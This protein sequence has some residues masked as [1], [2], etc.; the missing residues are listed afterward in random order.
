MAIREY[1]ECDTAGIP[2]TRLLAEIKTNPAL[3][4]GSPMAVSVEISM[5]GECHIT[6]AAFDEFVT[7]IN[8]KHG[9]AIP[10]HAKQW[11]KRQ[12][13]ERKGGRVDH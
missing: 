11:E 9:E 2:G 7:E 1:I 4:P 5:H 12:Q 10:L 6:K 3:E 13:A 8:L